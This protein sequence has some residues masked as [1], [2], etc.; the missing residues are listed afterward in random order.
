MDSNHRH[1]TSKNTDDRTNTHLDRTSSSTSSNHTNNTNN[2]ISSVD[3]FLLFDSH[4]DRTHSIVPASSTEQ[5]TTAIGGGGGLPSTNPMNPFSSRSDIV[6][7][8]EAPDTGTTTTTNQITT[9][10]NIGVVDDRMG[11]EEEPEDGK[12]IHS[13]NN[14]NNN[15]VR[16]GDIITTST[17]GNRCRLGSNNTHTSTSTGWNTVR[18]QDGPPDRDTTGSAVGV[19][20]QIYF[21][22]DGM[23]TTVVTVPSTMLE[24]GESSYSL[25]V[26]ASTSSP[27][28]PFLTTSDPTISASRHHHHN[29]N[30]LYSGT[31]SS[32]QTR[33]RSSSNQEYNYYNNNSNHNSSRRR[34]IDTPEL[35]GLNILNALTYTVH[36][37]IWWTCGVWG[38][39]HTMYTHW[40]QTQQ[41]ETLITP[42]TWAAHY[43]WVPI[44]IFEAVF[45]VA[46][47]LPHYRAR[48]IIT[49]GT[50]YFFFYT[51]LLQITY[52]LLYGFGL[53]VFSFI[54][55]V[56]ALFALLSLLASQQ[57]HGS[58][59][60][61][62]TTTTSTL[63]PFSNRGIIRSLS[64]GHIGNGRWLSSHQMIEYVL[65]SFPFY[66]HTGWLI[67]MAVDHFS[68]LFRR[69]NSAIDAQLASDIVGL[70]V[71]L[72]AAMYALNQPMA[73][74]PDFVIPTVIL[75]SYVR[76][77]K[78][79]CAVYVSSFFLITRN[80]FVSLLFVDW[81]C[82]SIV[83][84]K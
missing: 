20:E 79:V 48:P 59:D 52:T 74:G 49:S 84:P 6:V 60:M 55:I 11:G 8:N 22:E 21:V 41:H 81:D 53:F 67:L 24:R 42:S 61:T 82:Q 36:I 32:H 45:T 23:D 12:C 19:D 35:S 30:R 34:H 78:Y 76:V 14:S 5:V 38:M 46:Q 33:R 10:S 50:S 73:M 4:H 37:I 16:D 9:T 57:Y 54:S 1:P 28:T 15:S 7:H 77:P 13:N 29:R 43:L 63:L 25:L 70:G 83:F 65:F 69:Y 62:A 2:N 18:H 51:V 80:I 17:S 26:A 72:V 68:L 75:W 66:L 64:G 3:Y 44:M 39:D 31:S 58:A 27:T 56:L 71:L 40:E 47:L